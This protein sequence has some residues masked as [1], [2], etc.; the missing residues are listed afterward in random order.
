MAKTKKKK[1]N[2]KFSIILIVFCFLLLV[3]FGA[4][5]IDA[6]KEI[7][8]QKAQLSELQAKYDN[9][10][11]ENEELENALKE[12]DEAALAEEYARDKGYVMPDERVYVDIT[13]GSQE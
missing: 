10:V 8:A 6:Q 9:Q 2:N 1:Q 3:Y 7:N 11:A 13:P 12:N 5:Y 4:R